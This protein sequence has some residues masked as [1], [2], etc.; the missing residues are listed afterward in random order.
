MSQ[1]LQTADRTAT[2]MVVVVCGPSGV[3]KTTVAHLLAQRLQ[4]DF[5]EGD[6]YHPQ[7]N[8]D[9]MMA[10]SFVTPRLSVNWSPRRFPPRRSLP[11]WRKRS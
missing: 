4:M 10:A 9:K 1:A 5:R 7:A 3:G 2:P 11:R 8:I 6:T